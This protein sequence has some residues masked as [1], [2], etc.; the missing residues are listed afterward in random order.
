MVELPFE[1]TVKVTGTLAADQEV[2][3]ATKLS[4][5]LASINADIGTPVRR[6]QKIAELETA[7][8]KLRVEQALA[9]LAQARALAGMPPGDDDAQLAADETAI[10]RQAKATLDEA[11][12]KLERSRALAKEGL[13]TKSDLDAAEAAAVRAETALQSAR[14]EVRIRSA[15]VRQ[16]RSEVNL[17]RQQL[18]DTTLKSPLDGI[19]QTRLVNV[20]EFLSA[21]ARVATIVRIDPLRMRVAIPE[22][23]AT[24][25]KSDQLVRLRVDG[26]PQSYTGTVARVSP[27]LESQSRSLLVEADVKNPGNLKPGSFVNAEIVIGSKPAPAVPASAVV[28]FAGLEKVLI[29]KDDKAVEKQ[30]TTG[31]TVGDRIE[32]VTGIAV[33]ELVVGRPGSL[34]QGHRVR[35][36]GGT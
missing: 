19:V 10:V 11:R 28:R 33:G 7:D 29:V 27:A 20:G 30:V 26:D 1:R 22:R 6:D 8:Y 36:V 24:S 13:M 25:V 17:A 31:R 35:V 34:Q 2:T 12:S 5:R 4:G 23:D 16:R 3:V 18:A 15:S 14:D 21:G 32:I 9:S